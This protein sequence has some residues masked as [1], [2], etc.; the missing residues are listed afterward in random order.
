MAIKILVCPG[1]LDDHNPFATGNVLSWLKRAHPCMPPLLIKLGTAPLPWLI[2]WV[3]LLCPGNVVSL[4]MT[5]GRLTGCGVK[6]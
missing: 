6:T 3:I 2:Y 4:D 1:I 5:Q